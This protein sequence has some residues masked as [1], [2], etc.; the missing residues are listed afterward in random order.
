MGKQVKETNKATLEESM[1]AF[2]EKY[3]EVN[4]VWECEGV[5]RL[6]P[7]MACYDVSG[8]IYWDHLHEK[9]D[10]WAPVELDGPGVDCDCGETV[11]PGFV[12][13]AQLQKL[14]PKCSSSD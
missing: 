12:A 4:A 11:P 10:T 9:D 2:K 5:L 1:V 8:Q 3:G 14:H 7:F 13:M 6:G